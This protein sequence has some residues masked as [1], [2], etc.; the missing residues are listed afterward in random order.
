MKRAI[1]LVFVVAVLL[2]TVFASAAGA[3]PGGSNGQG[4]GQLGPGNG[5]PTVGSC[6]N[7]GNAF[8]AELKCHLM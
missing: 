8:G 3:T 4:G 5:Q 1:A 2:S 7:D 6:F